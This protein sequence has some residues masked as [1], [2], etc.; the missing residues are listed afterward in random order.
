MRRPA[1]ARVALLVNAA[2]ALGTAAHP[3]AGAAAPLHDVVIRHAL[4]YDGDGG[5]PF[6]GELAIDSDRIAYVGPHSAGKAR[7]EIDARGQ[8]VSPGFIDMMG[9]SEESLLID[10]RGVSALK[11]GVTLDVFTEL[12]MGPLTPEMAKL[13]RARQGDVRFEVT[14][15][16]LGQYLDELA[17]TA[18]PPTS[19]ASSARARCGST[20]SAR[21]TCS[22]RRRSSR[23]CA[24]SCTRRWSKGRSG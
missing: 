7:L 20:Y 16:T 22:R 9:H 12:S 3:A 6:A 2:A 17:G 24:R 18:S 1:A 10:G 11:Q 15:S 5:A 19:R 13:M 14:W 23:R 8:A 4:I 21:A